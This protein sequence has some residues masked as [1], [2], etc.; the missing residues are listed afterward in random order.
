MITKEKAVVCWTVFKR[1]RWILPAL[2]APLAVYL[3]GWVA[4]ADEYGNYAPAIGDMLVYILR[5][6][7]VTEAVLV[8]LVY[9]KDFKD[10]LVNLLLASVPLLILSYPAGWAVCYFNPGKWSAF[11]GH[12]PIGLLFFPI[13][14]VKY[15][16]LVAP[17]LGIAA[18]I[19]M[20]IWGYRVRRNQYPLLNSIAREANFWLLTLVSLTC[21]IVACA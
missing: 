18:G 2:L 4:R 1:Y 21:C 7:L 16:L 11:F 8:A 14:Y 10:L 3:L 17:L 12:T 13:L 19:G 6:G 15:A 5:Y 20:W 9:A